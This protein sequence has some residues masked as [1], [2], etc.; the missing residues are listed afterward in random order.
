M[1]TEYKNI[2]EKFPRKV[3]AIVE[4]PGN[5]AEQ[6]FSDGVKSIR[7]NK[8]PSSYAKQKPDYFNA[9]KAYARFGA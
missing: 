8:K 7:K 9:G 3:E 1:K 5:P 4:R 2:I 6:A